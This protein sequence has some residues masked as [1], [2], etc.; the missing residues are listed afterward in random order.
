[1]KKYSKIMFCLKHLEVI[2]DKKNEKHSIE[3]EVQPT[4][5]PC[6]IWYIHLLHIAGRPAATHYTFI[7]AEF[8]TKIG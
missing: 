3:C 5:R 1:M 4:C 8:R 7:E 2:E 6:N